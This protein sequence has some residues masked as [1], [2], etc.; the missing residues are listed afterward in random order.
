MIFAGYTDSKNPVRNILKN[1]VHQPCF[2]QIDFSEIKYRQQGVGVLERV[3]YRKGQCS[4]D[5]ESLLINWHIFLLQTICIGAFVE[6]ISDWKD[7][8]YHF[9]RNL[10]NSTLRHAFIMFQE[11]D[12]FAKGKTA[13]STL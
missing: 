8:L 1:P 4:F 6:D 9:K 13:F 10:K 5:M 12:E 2:F 11:N 3:R 7:T